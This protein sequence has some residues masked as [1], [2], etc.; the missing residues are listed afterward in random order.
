MAA[1]LPVLLRPSLVFRW[2]IF[3]Y[4]GWCC[5][6]RFVCVCVCTRQNVQGWWWYPVKKERGKVSSGSNSRDGASHVEFLSL[7]CDFLLF[8]VTIEPSTKL[9]ESAPA[10]P[11]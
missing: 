6:V 1:A 7:I 3:F 8:V 5:T 9:V 4:G 10:A 2:R 11:H